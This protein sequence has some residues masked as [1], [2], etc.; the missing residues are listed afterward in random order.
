MKTLLVEGVFLDKCSLYCSSAHVAGEGVGCSPM[1]QFPFAV[2]KMDFPIL[3]KS[4]L[5]Q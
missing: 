3:R 5:T 1:T 2:V 4:G